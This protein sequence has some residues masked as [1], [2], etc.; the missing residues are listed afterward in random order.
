VELKYKTA[1]WSDVMNI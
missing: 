1:I